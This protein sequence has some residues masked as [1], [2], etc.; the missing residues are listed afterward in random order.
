MLHWRPVTGDISS[1]T[2][3]CFFLSLQYIFFCAFF[4]LILSSSIQ[5]VPSAPIES[6]TNG[7]KNQPLVVNPD[8]M[9][10]DYLLEDIDTA[11][12]NPAK[13]KITRKSLELDHWAIVTGRSLAA[14]DLDFDTTCTVG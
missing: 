1:G 9:Q 3:L 12:A 14:T 13:S 4:D 11:G 10:V 2:Y 8:S 7:V 5:A 6:S